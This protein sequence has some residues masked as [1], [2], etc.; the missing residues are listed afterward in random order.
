TYGVV[1]KAKERKTSRVVAMKKMRL[2]SFTG[3]V[4]YTTIREISI[5]KDASHNNIV[6]LLDTILQEKNLYLVFEYCDMDLR[7]YL[8]GAPFG[9]PVDIIK[10]FTFQLLCGIKYCHSRRI[11]HRDLKPQNLLIGLDG[12]LK[13]A[14]FGLARDFSNSIGVLTHEVVTLWYRPPE[15]LLGAR[16]YSTSVDMWSVGCIFAEMMSSYA[17]FR[18]DSEIDQLFKIFGILGTPDEHL[19]P[20][21]HQLPN[22]KIIFPIWRRYPLDQIFPWMCYDAINLL[23][24]LLIYVPNQRIAAKTAL[25]HTYF[26]DINFSRS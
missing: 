6:R 10:K 8:D 22:F 11:L 17:L 15:L 5:L 3:R 16:C 2:E 4:S 24:K 12:N 7:K 18:G 14:D 20:G 26:D 13:L 1:Y 25:R 21:V 19:W 9:L 23:E